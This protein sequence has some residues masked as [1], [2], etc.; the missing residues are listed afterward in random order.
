MGCFSTENTIL[1][2]PDYIVCVIFLALLVKARCSKTAVT[3]KQNSDCRI[4]IQI[5][6]KYWLQE[7][8]HSS[9][10]ILCS[11]TKLD[12]YQIPGQSIIT[13]KRMVSI[14]LIVKVK[15]AAFLFT[16]C[17]KKSGIQIQNDSLWHLNT[18]NSFSKY[19]ANRKE[20]V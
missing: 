5:F 16:V 11:I 4:I 15:G 1:L 8:N 10:G 3:T 14:A 19:S 2:Q 13:D 18:V 17:V 9:A 6:I 12:F 20:L 7:I